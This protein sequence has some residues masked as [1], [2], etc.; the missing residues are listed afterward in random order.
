MTPAAIVEFLLILL[1]AASIIAMVANRFRIPYTVAL[2]FGGFGI[3]FFHVPIQSLVAY[4]G[5]SQIHLLTPEVVFILF[6]PP[7][8]FEA[9]INLDLH[10]LR[11]NL[12]PITLLAIGGVLIAMSATGLSVHWFVG[13]PI[14]PAMIF[15]ALISA[16][17]PVSVLALFKGLGISKRLAMLIEGESLFNDGTA[18]VLFQILVVAAVTTGSIDVLDGVRQFLI[19][20]S[21][22]AVLGFGLGYAASRVTQQIDE[23]RIEITLTT[24]LAYG[25]YLLAEHL[26]VSGVIATVVAAVV[27]GNFGA[28]IG[29][30]ARTRLA[31]WS[32]WDYIAFV[33][34]SLVFLL[35][36][37][38]VHLLDLVTSWRAILLALAMVLLGRALAV[39]TL[40][41]LC[42]L[43][44][45]SIPLK[46]QHL[47]VWGGLHGGLSIALALSLRENLPGRETILAMTF[48]VVAFS[49]TV[50]GLTLKP[51]LRLLNIEVGRED[52]FDRTRVKVIALNA[53]A[54][55][56]DLLQQSNFTTPSTY[57]KLHRELE[58]SMNA[59][60]Q[61][62]DGIEASR[63]AGAN[64]QMRIARMR[65][66]SAEKSAIR[67]SLS[68][69][70]ISLSAA[71]KLL[72]SSD[73][74]LDN[75]RR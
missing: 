15:G 12:L 13:L 74:D 39:Y 44:G 4:G 60:Q 70:L 55:E 24:I 53:A 66:L 68:D 52:D 36:G 45:Q 21:G 29:M 22:G 28:E 72:E 2:V 37:I 10:H 7:L 75:L 31:I 8:L 19:V 34:N 47:I 20:V 6:L 35:V 40:S 49:I 9:G 65:M 63:P 59:A 57:T 43:A 25:S 11:S 5:T 69:G 64:E 38:E 62:M 14:L 50:Q 41:P 56:L 67:R 42:R 27:V 33:A 58:S 26:H 71:E 30:S 18:I 3:N 46:W 48:G 73:Q 54:R 16:T 17:D 32:F 1:I 23:P 61:E 51:A